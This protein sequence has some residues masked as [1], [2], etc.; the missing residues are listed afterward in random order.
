MLSCP[1]SSLT[2]ESSGD[3]AMKLRD[4]MNPEGV[5]VKTA[6][7]YAYRYFMRDYLNSVR[8]VSG[9]EQLTDYDPLGQILVYRNQNLKDNTYLYESK[10]LYTDFSS[11]Y[12]GVYDFGA[13]FYNPLYGRW[14]APD[15]AQ[16]G[17]NPYTYCGN[18][19]VML[20]DPDGRIMH[21]WDYNWFYNMDVKFLS[22]LYKKQIRLMRKMENAQMSETKV[23]QIQRKFDKNNQSIFRVQEDM[24]NLNL[25]RED[26]KYTYVMTRINA[27][28][29]EKLGV[30]LRDN[31]IVEVQYTSKGNAAH[32]RAHIGQS[33]NANYMEFDEVTKGL[34]NAAE[35]LPGNENDNSDVQGYYKLQQKTQNEVDAYRIQYVFDGPYRLPSNN[36]FINIE[37]MY[38]MNPHSLANIIY[39]GTPLYPFAQKYINHNLY[40]R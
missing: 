1:A 10:E 31:N 27:N 29:G 13:R 39:R 36:G 23:A 18:N 22:L 16:Q 14:F 32:E 28:S 20:V 15:P 6:T 40:N 2:Y 4:M 21:K 33:I 35:I 5:V 17:I 26:T 8:H 19:P 9:I 30:Y 25:M 11:A 34:Y 7:G 38:D 24:N 37:E 3:G 12:M